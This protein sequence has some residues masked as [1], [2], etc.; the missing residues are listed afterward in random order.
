MRYDDTAIPPVYDRARGLIPGMVGLWMRTIAARLGGAPVSAIL[1]LGA[2]TGRFSSALA[3]QWHAGVLGLDPSRKMLA[4]AVRKRSDPR[5]HYAAGYGERLPLAAR[6]VD[7]VFL[8][9]VY[10]HFV[11]PRRAAQECRRVLR[12]GGHVVVRTGS[13]EQVDNY[14]PVRFFPG[15]RGLLERRLPTAQLLAGV[16]HRAGL[17]QLSHELVI[18]EIARDHQDFAERPALGADSVLAS[19]EL[20]EFQEGVNALRAHAETAGDAPVTEPIDLFVFRRD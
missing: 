5:V 2:G 17:E 4:E 10:H 3:A 16:F 7:L 20:G 6:S 11:D 14:P 15:M 1:D 9:M 8:S 19:L 12:P 13:R 18:Q